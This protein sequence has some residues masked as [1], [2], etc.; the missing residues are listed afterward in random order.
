MQDYVKVDY[1]ILT[2]NLSTKL[3]GRI[4]RWWL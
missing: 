1:M 3:D 4:E 2:D